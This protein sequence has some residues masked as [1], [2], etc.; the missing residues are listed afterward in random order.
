MIHLHV[1]LFSFGKKMMGKKK[2]NA[3]AAPIMIITL[4][5]PPGESRR[6]QYTTHARAREFAPRTGRR[7]SAAKR[8]PRRRVPGTSVR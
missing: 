7:V 4:W 3:I 2:K 6:R 5:G 1:L 8:S